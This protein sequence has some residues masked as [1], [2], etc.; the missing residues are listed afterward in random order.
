MRGLWVAFSL[1]SSEL[2]FAK[3][4]LEIDA[5][6][7]EKYAEQIV[8]MADLTGGT[9]AK[10]RFG[11]SNVGPGDGKA[12]CEFT[13]IEKDGTIFSDEVLV[14]REQWGSEKSTNTLKVGPCH[15]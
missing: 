9:Y 14:E 13:I 6:D 1:L 4:A 7:D 8:A 12:G 3:G 5:L 11:I 10:I 15:A 2:A